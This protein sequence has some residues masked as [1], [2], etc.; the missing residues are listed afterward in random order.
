MNNKLIEFARYH[1]NINLSSVFI[2]DFGFKGNNPY[3]WSSTSKS[4]ENWYSVEME[5]NSNGIII[6]EVNHCYALG[7]VNDEIVF[8]END[9]PCPNTSNNY[10]NSSS[11]DALP[12][13]GGGSKSR[14]VR[15]L[16]FEWLKSD[17]IFTK[18]FT[19]DTVMVSIN[20]SF[21]SRW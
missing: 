15:K 6:D 4:P 3:G 17:E 8:S 2:D 12:Y 18:I 13:L 19:T 21:Y 10:G 5:V 20:S 7:K 11:N 9:F 16:N 1:E 14:K